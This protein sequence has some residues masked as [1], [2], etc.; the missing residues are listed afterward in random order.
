MGKVIMI[1][2]F[3]KKRCLEALLAHI[4]LPSYCE[5]CI[6]DIDSLDEEEY[7]FETDVAVGGPPQ[8]NQPIPEVAKVI[9][10]PSKKVVKPHTRKVA[11][12]APKA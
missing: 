12:Q 6:D 3:R 1:E 8:V 4:G 9:P 5:E 2:E 11:R 10:F 7:L